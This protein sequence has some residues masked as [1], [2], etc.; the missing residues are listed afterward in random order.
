MPLS[1]AERDRRYRAVRGMMKGK[2][3]SA[4]LVASSAMW[5]GH[6]RYFSNYAPS[7]GYIYLVFPGEGDPTQLVFT[8]GMA[9]IA[10]KGWVRDSRRAAPSY[11]DAIVNRIRELGHADKRIG[12]VGSENISFE[13]FDQV[14]N[15]LPLATFVNAT[16]E[17][18]NLRMIKSAEEQALVRQAGKIAD[19]LFACIKEV[20]KPGLRECD[21]Y[22]EMSAFMWKQGVEGAFNPI[23]SGQFPLT[24]SLSPSDRV[25]A[26]ED[27]ILIEITPRFQGYYCQLTAVH[28]LR[29]PNPK[30][31]K[32]L[33]VAFAAQEA[34]LGVLKAG[35]RA[36]DVAQAMKDV[37][38][39]SGY[40]FPYRGGHSFGH[41][42]DEPPAITVQDDTMLAPGMTVVVHPSVMDASGDGIFVGD[43]YIIT[44]TGWERLNKSFSKS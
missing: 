33:E 25:L 44:D 22:A 19:D 6:V 18:R 14:R 5:A 12:L 27:S 34:G 8:E 24:L 40:A 3:L 15:Q 7:E 39:K 38:E 13:L 21:V 17:I 42:L 16:R 29:A 4:L 26:P 37:V 1:I 41:D 11:P 2:E 30:M 28:P 9:K 43:S 20:A 10:S 31:K 36:R 32:F 35:D 23:G